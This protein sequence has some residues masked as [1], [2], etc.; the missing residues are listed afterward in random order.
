MLKRKSWIKAGVSAIIALT[1]LAGCSGGGTPQ[2]SQESQSPSATKDTSKAKPDLKVLAFNVGFDPN[3]D[4]V[5]SDIEARTGYKVNYT[6]LPKDKPEEKLNIEIASG[7]NYDILSLSPTQFNTLVAQG[8][9]QPIGDLVEQHGANMKDAISEASWDLGKYN[10]ELY[11]IPQKNER[12]NIEQTLIVREDILSELGLKMPETLDEFYNTL[13]TIKEKKPDMIPLTGQ[14]MH[15]PMIYSGFGLSTAWSEVDGQL[16]PRIKQPAMVEYITFMKKLYD[17]GLVDKD[18]SI[19]KTAQAQEKFIGGKAAMISGNWNDAS[20]MNGAFTTNIPGGKMGYML[21]LKGADGQAGVEV[22]DKLLWVHAIPKSSKNAEEAIKFMDSKLQM[23]NFTFLTLGEKGVTFN[24]EN[25]VYSPI[26]PIFTEQRGNAYFYLNGIHEVEY[27]EMWLARLR[28]TPTLFES[29]N[30]INKDFDKYAKS[31]PISFMPPIEEVGKNLPSLLQ[32]END[33]FLQVLMNG[34][35]IDGFDKFMKS[36]DESG[37]AAVIK[38][39]NE[40]HQAKK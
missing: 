40:W 20:S 30:A 4:V 33:Y 17:E 21:P 22:S 23:D 10:G 28:R 15:V 13:K 14:G 12:A 19:N 6:L 16:L 18:W 27:A 3:T 36:W 1:V 32:K 9:L 35:K 34:E 7:V 26:M 24:E 5:A 37:G 31:N 2:A 25:G 11:G 39:I 38:A 8:A 29:F